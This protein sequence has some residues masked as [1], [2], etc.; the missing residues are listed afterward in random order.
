MRKTSRFL[1]SLFARA[2][3]T[4]IILNKKEISFKVCLDFPKRRIASGSS[5][6]IS[7]RR[8]ISSSDAA[9][10]AAALVL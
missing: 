4:K 6:N 1:T 9:T 3:N 2:N 5:R 10:S 7:S 8:I